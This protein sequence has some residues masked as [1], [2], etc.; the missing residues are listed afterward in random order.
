MTNNLSDFFKYIFKRKEYK[1]KNLLFNGLE[2]EYD[3]KEHI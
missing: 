3:K 2:C 1:K